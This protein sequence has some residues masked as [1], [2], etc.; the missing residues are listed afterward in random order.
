MHKYPT[1]WT[2]LMLA[3]L[4]TGLAILYNKFP[5][6]AIPLAANAPPFINLSFISYSWYLFA[7]Y[8]AMLPSPLPTYLNA[9]KYPEVFFFSGFKVPW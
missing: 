5:A 1:P 7:K 2:V 4:T 3:Y 8:E 9:S 6:A